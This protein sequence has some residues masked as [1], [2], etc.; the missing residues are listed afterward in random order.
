M[1][2]AARRTEPLHRGP[3]PATTPAA[4]VLMAGAR[5]TMSS[6]ARHTEALTCR[7]RP[8]KHPFSLDADAWSKAH[9]ALHSTAHRAIASRTRPC[10]YPCSSSADGW[11]KA[12]HVLHSTAHGGVGIPHQALEKAH[13]PC[14][15]IRAGPLLQ[16]LPHGCAACAA[17]HAWLS[18]SSVVFCCLV[19]LVV[20]PSSVLAHRAAGCVEGL[21]PCAAGCIRGLWARWRRN[22]EL[23][24]ACMGMLDGAPDSRGWPRAC[25]R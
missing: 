22:F 1:P 13:I 24:H 9:N 17:Q 20:G 15:L 18:P 12:H 5:L 8:V 16:E 4:Q 3:G 2:S 19:A 11:S 23:L 10:N 21:S 7:T 6:T 25:C 14:G